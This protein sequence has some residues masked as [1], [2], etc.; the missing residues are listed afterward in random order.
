MAYKHIFPTPQQSREAYLLAKFQFVITE[1]ELAMTFCDI[2]LS[3]DGGAKRERNI[4]NAKRAH[5]AGLHFLGEGDLSEQQ[6]KQV[7]DR[8]DKL[9]PMLRKATEAQAK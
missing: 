6:T 3:S 5:D 4:K 1:L 7:R 8:L 2:A 9:E